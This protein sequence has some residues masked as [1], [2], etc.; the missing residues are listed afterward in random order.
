VLDIWTWTRCFTLYIAVVTKIRPE[1][2][3]VMVAHLHTVYKL[4]QRAPEATA[5]LK[6]NVLFRM[7]PTPRPP[8][9]WDKG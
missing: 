4:Q 9:V 5:W 8:R 3:L 6:Y 1:M 2:V 7:A